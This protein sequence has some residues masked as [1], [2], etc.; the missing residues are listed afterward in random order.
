MEIE[1][2]SVQFLITFEQTVS[3]RVPLKI[4]VNEIAFETLKAKSG[5]LSQSSKPFFQKDIKL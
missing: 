3:K 5:K 2:K 4:S 1:K